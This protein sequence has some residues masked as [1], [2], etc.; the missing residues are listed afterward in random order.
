MR[1]SDVQPRDRCDGHPHP[2]RPLPQAGPQS[3]AGR[4]QRATRSLRSKEPRASEPQP[5]EP[6]SASASS[7]SRSVSGF[8]ASIDVGRSPNDLDMTEKSSIKRLTC[9]TVARA[10]DLAQETLNSTCNTRQSASG[11]RPRTLSARPK[12]RRLQLE[13]AGVLLEC[14]LPATQGESPKFPAVPAR[15]G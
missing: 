12:Q 2:R 10:R 15:N 13:K 7:P 9:R 3:R 6:G 5:N 4:R 8:P 11:N 1:R 14:D